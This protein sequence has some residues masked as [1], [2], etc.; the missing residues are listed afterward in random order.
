[1]SGTTVSMEVV[2][3]AWVTKD[4]QWTKAELDAQSCEVK[5]QF[6]LGTVDL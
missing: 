5:S 6:E 1:M 2:R 3:I 4:G